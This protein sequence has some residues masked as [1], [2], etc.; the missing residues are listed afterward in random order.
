[1]RKVRKSLDATRLHYQARTRRRLGEG[2]GG[3]GAVAHN[4]FRHVSTVP[5]VEIGRAVI[6]PAIG[7]HAVATK[8]SRLAWPGAF[9]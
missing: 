7:V 9:L 3:Y 4:G 8:Q 1:M 2:A 6:R 5:A